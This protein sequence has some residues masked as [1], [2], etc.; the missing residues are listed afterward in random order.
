MGRPCTLPERVDALLDDG[1]GRPNPQLEPLREAILAMPRH[2]SASAWIRG[3]KARLLLR[4]LAEGNLPLTHRA[5][6]EHP[7]WRAAAHLR[8][9]L[10]ACALLPQAD[11]YLLHYESWL[12]RRFNELYDRAH[13]PLLEQFATWHQLPKLRA[14]AERRPLTPS[15]RSHASQQFNRANGFLTWLDGQGLT[16]KQ[17]GQAEIDRWHATHKPHE[18]LALRAFL[19]W[20][21][22]SGRLPSRPRFPRLAIAEGAPLTQHRRLELLRRVLDEDTGPLRSR[23]AACL[24][25]LF[26]Q[27]ASR[28]VLLTT[29][30]LTRDI[31]G[32]VLIRLG[33]PPTPVPEPFADLLLQARD[34]R[35]N[36]N[37]NNRDA[38]WLFPGRRAGRPMH[39]HSLAEL[40]RDIGV[41][42]TAVRSSALRQLVLQ[43]P[44]PVIAQALGFHDKTTTRV[45][46]QAGGTW[47]R[48]APSDHTQ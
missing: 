34:Q 30:D 26:A 21:R 42:G 11:K 35:T 37:T 44:A 33:D 48:Y 12:H 20:A 38:T 13:L 16:L 14:R 40:I 46:A 4:E 32:Q 25:L 23:A 41:P 2:R 31:N 27:P 45:V 15:A 36:M 19:T 10:M 7:E 47:S 39:P 1:T 43:A 24:M 28:I 22:N 8:D 3:P 29:D 18:Q 5:F 17:V 9:L 6:R